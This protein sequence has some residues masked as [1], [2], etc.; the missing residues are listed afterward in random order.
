VTSPSASPPTDATRPLHVV[1]VNTSDRGGGAEAVSRNL[2]E[3]LRARGERAELAV[4]F[5]RGDDPDTRWLAPRGGGPWAR[6]WNALAALAMHRLPTARATPTFVRWA[7]RTATP[8]AWLDVWR[9]HEIFRHPGTWRLADPATPAPDV[10]HLHNLHG[11]Y[12]DLRALPALA[13]RAPTLLTLHDAWLLSG[14]CSHSLGCERWTS[15][16]GDC[17]HLDTFPAIRTDAT[18]ENWRR[19]REI[20]RACRVRVATPSRWLL[21]KVERSMLAPSV[22]EGRVIPNGVDLEVFAPGERARLRAEA[23]LAPD[24]LVLAFVAHRFRTPHS[25]KDWATVREAAARV[26]ERTARAVHLLAVG[27]GPDPSEE[28]GRARVRFVPEAAPAE[29]ARHLRMADV[30]LHAARPE[31]ENYPTVVLEALACGT[32][33]VA[34]AVGGIPEQVVPL[35]RAGSRDGAPPE[36]ATGALVPPGDPAAMA[37]AVA[38]LADDETLRARLAA[39]AARDAAAR[40]GLARQIEAYLAWYRE[41]ADAPRPEPPARP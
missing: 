28:T 21:D 35:A 19:K 23:G 31:A 3:A 26:A 4:G 22:V 39:N 8:G 14:H 15:G 5:R 29:V 38:T 9:G 13:G 10:Y 36:R 34:T 27:D 11:G 37:A 24:A 18:R 6:P 30:A 32:P 1:Q 20:Y 12:F 2:F 7:W 17:P 41:L 33:V 40:H 25:W 16:C